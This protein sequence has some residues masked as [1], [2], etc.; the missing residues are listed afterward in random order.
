MADEREMTA[1]DVRAVLAALGAVPVPEGL[2]ALVLEQARAHRANMRRFDAA[3]IDLAGVVT[4]QPYR[5]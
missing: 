4:A 3:G 1:E 5:A 2:M